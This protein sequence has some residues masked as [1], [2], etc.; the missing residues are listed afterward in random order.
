MKAMKTN[1]PKIIS[2]A[3]KPPAKGMIS[4]GQGAATKKTRFVKNG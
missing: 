4:R 3:K 1:Q 2:V